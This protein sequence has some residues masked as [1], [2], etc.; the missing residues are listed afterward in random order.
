MLLELAIFNPSNDLRLCVNQEMWNWNK[1][2]KKY[3]NQEPRRVF[4]TTPDICHP[5]SIKN[6]ALTSVYTL[7]LVYYLH[8]GCNFTPCLYFYTQ[9]VI[10]IVLFFM[11]LHTF[12]C[13]KLSSQNA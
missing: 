13:K 3:V 10:Y 8:S 5:L 12:E 6:T 7:Q 2:L 1:I 9:C 4:V 11:N